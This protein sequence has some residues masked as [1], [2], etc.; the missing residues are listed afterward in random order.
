[1]AWKHA[2]VYI[3]TTA[4]SPKY[5]DKSLVHFLNS[6]GKGKVMYGTDFPVLTHAESLKEINQLELKP[7]AIKA[8]LSDT[9][10]KVYK[11]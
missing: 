4:H 6:R 11:L 3:A 5:W 2:N 1:M 10:R 7:E 8:L 9:A